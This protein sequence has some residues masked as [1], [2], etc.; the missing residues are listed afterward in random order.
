MNKNNKCIK[1]YE[2]LSKSINKIG[3]IDIIYKVIQ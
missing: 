2:L 3:K 1:A